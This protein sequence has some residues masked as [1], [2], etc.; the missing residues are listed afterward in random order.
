MLGFGSLCAADAQAARTELQSIETNSVTNKQEVAIRTKGEKIYIS[1]RGGAF[2][3]LFLGDTPEA[4]YFRKLLMEAGAARG[5]IS[6]P[7]GSIIVANGGGKQD[8][9]KPAPPSG[10][11]QTDKAKQLSTDK[12]APTGKSE[13]AK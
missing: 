9:V 3:E 6:V 2:E 13:K 7:I 1:Q 8:G 11:K 10:D 12:Q 5:P 4:E